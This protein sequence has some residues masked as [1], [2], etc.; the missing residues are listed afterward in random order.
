M[1]D[2]SVN[3]FA[4]LGNLYYKFGLHNILEAIL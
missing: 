2:I 3:Y 1:I 4:D